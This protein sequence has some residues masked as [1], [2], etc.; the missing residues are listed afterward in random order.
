MSPSADFPLGCE[1]QR[2]PELA[3]RAAAITYSEGS[4]KLV[5]DYS[6]NLKGL[7]RGMP[8]QQALSLYGEMDILQADMPHYWS[9]FN[10]ILDL[11][12]TKSPLVEGLQLEKYI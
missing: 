3:P 6:G 10:S 8:L 12:E 11:L 4:Q 2:H 7:Q 1:I 5:L 9:S